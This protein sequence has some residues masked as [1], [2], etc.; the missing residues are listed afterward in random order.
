[1]S[2]YVLIYPVYIIYAVFFLKKTVSETFHEDSLIFGKQGFQILHVLKYVVPF[3]IA[4]V[5]NT[6][7]YARGLAKIS[8]SAAGVLIGLGPVVV[9]IESLIILKEKFLIRKVFATLFVF[10]GV[11]AISFDKQFTGDLFGI[12]LVLAAAAG[13]GTY[14]VN[15]SLGKTV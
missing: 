7:A 1:M 5:L 6:Y 2:W 14:N 9:F 10:G 8:A 12:I 4:A 3:F 11:I 15:I 13:F